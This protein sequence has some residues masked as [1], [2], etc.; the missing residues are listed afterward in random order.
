MGVVKYFVESS[1][2]CS[3]RLDAALEAQFIV[4]EV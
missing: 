2:V 3:S 4:T 1:V